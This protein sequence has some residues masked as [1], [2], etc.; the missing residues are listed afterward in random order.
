MHLFTGM[1]YGKLKVFTL[2][3]GRE[4]LSWYLYPEKKKYVETD[5]AG[6]CILADEKILYIGG[7]DGQ[8]MEMLVK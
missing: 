1:Y 5:I 7:T 6:I 3:N 4:V 8:V 2:D